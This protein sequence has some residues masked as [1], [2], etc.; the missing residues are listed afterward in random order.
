MPNLQKLLFKAGFT[1]ING[2]G[3]YLCPLTALFNFLLCTV[4][5]VPLPGS[6]GASEGSFMLLYS[7]MVAA[8]N[9]FPMMMLSRGIS[10]Y[11]FLA[12]SG[13]ATLILQFWKAGYT[14]E[15]T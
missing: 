12:V 14:K 9:V 10:F 7:G 8:G 5:A 13:A 6:V 15:N 1:N 2:N 4:T 11:G 3:A